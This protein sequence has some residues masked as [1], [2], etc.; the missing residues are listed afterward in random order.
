MSMPDAEGKKSLLS[1]VAMVLISLGITVLAIYI[2]VRNVDMQLVWS[3]LK[4]MPLWPYACGLGLMMVVTVVRALRF[5]VLMRA[6]RSTVWASLEMVLIGYFFS[7]VL[8]FRAGELVRIG[9]FSRRVNVP[10]LSV[11]SATMV[12]RAMDLT[13]L[14]LL[15]AVFLSSLVGHHVEQL[16]ISPTTLAALAGAGVVGGIVVGLLARLRLRRAA[17]RSNSKLG[18]RVDEVLAGFSSLGSITNVLLGFLLSLAIWLLVT[19]SVKVAFWAPNIDLPLAHAG[20]IMLGTCFAIALPPTPAAVGTYHL[21]FV[22]AAL[23]VGLTREVSLPVAI[24]FHLM[25]QLPFLPIA[26]VIL[27]T[28]GRRVLARPPDKPADKETDQK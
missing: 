25:I 24:V 1:R 28:G 20:V 7:I 27:F 6:M 4:Q 3:S 10:V 21:G 14:A 8:P 16:P 5:H 2:A 23:L 17:P 26:G 22:A 11:A 19:L 18:H 12:E 15:G 9:Y 13:T